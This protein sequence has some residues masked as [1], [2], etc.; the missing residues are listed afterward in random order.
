MLPIISSDACQKA[1]VNHVHRREF[2]SPEELDYHLDF[3]TV[4]IIFRKAAFPIPVKLINN[5]NNAT[6][7]RRNYRMLHTKFNE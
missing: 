1:H 3:K 6:D 2:P 5:K 7:F 4:L